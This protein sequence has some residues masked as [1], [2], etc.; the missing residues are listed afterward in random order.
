V[1]RPIVLV[2]DDDAP[3]RR[4]F[5]IILEGAGF[6]CRVAGDAAGATAEV[7]MGDIGVALCDVR[8]GEEDGLGLATS[9]LEHRSSIAVVMVTGVD[10]P[11]MAET[12]VALGAYGYLVKPVRRSE[13]IL[14]VTNALRRRELEMRQREL[15]VDLEARVRERTAELQAALER[16]EQAEAVRSQFVQN[17]SHELR[18]PLTVILAGAGLISRTPDPERLASIAAS[19]ESQGK[20]LLQLI[21]RLIEV[22]SLDEDRPSV[23]VVPI[24][25]R[26]LLALAAD[27]ARA[28]GREVTI[29]VRGGTPLVGSQQRLVS[30]LSHLVE[31][32]V[33]FTPPTARLRMQAAVDEP[34]REWVIEVA[35]DG[36][37]IPE[38]I[39]DRM[40][41]PFVQA[42]GSAVRERGGLGVG[43]Y[44]CRRLVEWHGGQVK[45]AETP[46]GG[47]TV[48]IRLPTLPPG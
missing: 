26:G 41:E 36:P 32:A 8:L 25:V 29:D 38:E 47:L 1:S 6:D 28:A 33:K 19:I 10:D 44:L 21:E 45:A 27:P 46:G 48:V 3:T 7:A 5:R 2:V 43:L 20:R 24:E 13:L 42:D 34:E 16:A 39:R 30:A 12:A 11:D 18:T 9:L 23:P 40:W 17:V 22:A 37:G 4:L 35:D 31:N 15:V 14:N